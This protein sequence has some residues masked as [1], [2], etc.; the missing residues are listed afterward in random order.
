M[1]IAARWDAP[2]RGD[3]RTAGDRPGIPP[4]RHTRGMPTHY[5]AMSIVCLGLALKRNL[6]GT[7]FFKA[8]VG[9]PSPLA[10]TRL[11]PR[12][13]FPKENKPRYYFGP[14]GRGLHSRDS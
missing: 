1:P 10:L 7:L 5:D 4:G 6:Q 11:A 2:G 8:G 14:D 9:R 13:T 3:L 12:H